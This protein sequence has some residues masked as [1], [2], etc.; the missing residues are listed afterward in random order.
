MWMGDRLRRRKI[1][2]EHRFCRFKDSKRLI[3]N[4][5][6]TANTANKANNENFAALN[7]SHFSFPSTTRPRRG[8]L[9]RRG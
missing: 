3:S 7:Y 5:T 9:L 2:M 6:N 4:I 1:W 8:R